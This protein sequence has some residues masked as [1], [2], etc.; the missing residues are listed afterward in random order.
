MLDNLLEKIAVKSALRV[1]VILLVALFVAL[2]FPEGIKVTCSMAEVLN[3]EVQTC[4]NI[5]KQNG[6]L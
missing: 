3:I 1:A 4:T 2:K 5:D 6:D